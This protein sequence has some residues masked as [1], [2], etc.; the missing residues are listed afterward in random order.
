MFFKL[1]NLNS[2]LAL[3]QGYLNLALNNSAQVSRRDLFVKRLLSRNSKTQPSSG[4][5]FLSPNN[6]QWKKT[7]TWKK[8]VKRKSLRHLAK[9][10]SLPIGLQTITTLRPIIA[11]IKPKLRPLKDVGDKESCIPSQILHPL[12]PFRFCLSGQN[13]LRL[14]LFQSEIGKY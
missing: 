11:I 7:T 9:P 14:E 8:K 13:T 10:V 4:I 6:N 2:N 12:S 1:L 3:T 5:A